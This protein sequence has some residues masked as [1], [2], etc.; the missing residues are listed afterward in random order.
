LIFS[1]YLKDEMMDN[2]LTESVL[3][4][5]KSAAAKLTGFKRREYLAEVA[6][7]YCD[8]SPR[9]AERWFGWGRDA[10]KTGLNEQRTGIRCVDNVKARGRKKT[11]ERI[12]Q[13]AEEIE[14]IVAPHAQADPKFQTP[15]A[16]T[17]ITAEAVRQ[18]LLKK[19]DLKDAVPC[20]QTVG[21]I[22]NRMDYRLR[23]VVKTIP[24][25]RFLRPTRSLPTS[26]LAGKRLVKMPIA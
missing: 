15:F 7:E 23:R 13:M 10:V 17:R 22:L 19:D 3:A 16:Y 9:K 1:R 20:R 8:G 5:I 24:Q 4:T 14:R 21:E 11:E 18:E 12:P 2:R 25:K 26:T 6:L